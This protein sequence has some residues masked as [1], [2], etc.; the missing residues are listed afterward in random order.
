MD[1]DIFVFCMRKCHFPFNKRST[2]IIEGGTFIQINVVSGNSK[3][4]QPP[5]RDFTVDVSCYSC[6]FERSQSEAVFVLQ[7]LWGSHD[8]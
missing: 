5:D 8:F 2:V 4:L 1:P 6:H 7:R 3:S